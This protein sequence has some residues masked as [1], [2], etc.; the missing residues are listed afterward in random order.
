M[1]NIRTLIKSMQ[2]RTEQNL[3]LTV[4]PFTHSQQAAV[5]GGISGKGSQILTNHRTERVTDN[6]T[7]RLAV[8]THLTGHPIKLT[9][10]RIT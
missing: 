8:P 1:Y 4:S 6:F 5:E 2:L 7:T 3:D 10:P 9:G